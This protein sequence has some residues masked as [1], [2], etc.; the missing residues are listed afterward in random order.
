MFTRVIHR[1]S[2]AVVAAVA[3]LSLVAS[4]GDDSKDSSPQTTQGEAA[5]GAAGAGPFF[6]NCGG[7][8]VAEV[9]KA[10]GFDGLTNT[11]RNPS[12]CEWV[13]PEGDI[14]PQV[15][16]NWYRGS[17][18]GRE[19]ATEQLTRDSVTDIEISGGKGFLASTTGLCE[20]GI[21]FGADFFEWS[22]SVGATAGGGSGQPSPGAPAPGQGQAPDAAT[23][24]MCDAVKQLGTLTISRSQK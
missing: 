1:R 2:I 10:T 14:G 8:E 3:A 22:A 17:P 7:V 12:V 16:F 19:R 20:L 9:S 18:I 15:S 11:V 5:P 23:E 4:C 6:G 13:T 21:A 24:K